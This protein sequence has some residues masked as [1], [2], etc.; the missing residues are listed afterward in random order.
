M[1]VPT[2]SDLNYNQENIEAPKGW[3]R[4]IACYSWTTASG[5]ITPV[6]FKV[7]EENGEIRTFN[8]VKVNFTEKKIYCGIPSFEY[9]CD[10]LINGVLV[11]KIL[12]YF[13]ER[14][15]WFLLEQPML[16][17]PSVCDIH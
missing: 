9:H 13:P 14:S 16:E 4:E 3:Q 6:M 8:Q 10:V 12:Q 11:Y 7:R 1:L 15:R 5:V 17:Q 2:G